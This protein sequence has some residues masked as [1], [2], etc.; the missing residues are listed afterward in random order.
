MMELLAR[1][2]SLLRRGRRLPAAAASLFRFGD[3][4]V[5]FEAAEVKKAGQPIELSALNCAC[6]AISSKGAARWCRATNCSTR[7]GATTSTSMT[8]TVDVH[9]SSLRQKIEDQPGKPRHLITVHGQGYI[10][11]PSTPACYR[12]CHR[13]WETIA[14]SR[15]YAAVDLAEPEPPWKRRTSRLLVHEKAPPNSETPLELLAAGKTPLPLFHPQQ[16]PAAC[17]DRP[18]GLAPRNRR[19]GGGAVRIDFA[20]LRSLPS[21]KIVSVLECTG[22]SRS[23]F[24]AAGGKAEGLPWVKAPSP[25]PNGRVCR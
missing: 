8:R 17:R 11:V 20:E 16:L 2:E 24:E 6:C 3:V 18:R 22:N 15:T 9:V 10:P 23:R 25:A 4:A 21:R 1:I 7:C 13:A 14:P 12:Q 5:D 19:R